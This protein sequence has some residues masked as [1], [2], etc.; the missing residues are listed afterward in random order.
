MDKYN[1]YYDE[2]SHSR[3]INKKT[4]FA[5]NYYENFI[6][7][8]IGWNNDKNECMNYSNLQG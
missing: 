8:I 7:T 4:F 3:N 6:A 2:S 5:D 1:F